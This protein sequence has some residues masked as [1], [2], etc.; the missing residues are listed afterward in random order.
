M[1]F[2]DPL[3]YAAIWVE[4]VH[5]GVDFYL[6]ASLIQQE[7]GF[8]PHAVGDA[9]TSYGL[10]QLNVNGAG[11]G[12]TPE[13][14]LDISRNI[15]LG[16]AY[17]RQ[18]LDAF[19]ADNR[20]AIAAYRQGIQGVRDNGWEVS[21]VYVCSIQERQDRYRVGGIQRYLPRRSLAYEM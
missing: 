18:C 5:Y 21:E 16:V 4:S 3:V 1:L 19:P 20:E 7:S 12:F 6:I 15:K 2:L 11:S 8:R 14:L 9:S 10:M 17:L 13:E